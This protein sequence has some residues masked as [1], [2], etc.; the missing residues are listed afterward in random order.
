LSVIGYLRFPAVLLTVYLGSISFGTLYMLNISIQQT[1]AEP[2]YNFSVVLVG[3]AY[4][5]PSLGYFCASLVGGRWT[6]AIMHREAKAAGRY[7]E[8]GK[9]ILRPEDR[10]RENAFLAAAIFP[11]GLL[12][13]GWTSDKGIFWFVP[14]VAN[15]FFG[16]GSMII[17]GTATTMYVSSS[18]LRARKK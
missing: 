7:D 14:L 9:L 15:F 11:A 13:Y 6:D 10:M 1:F 8:A 5:P 2:P 3:L 18:A 4:I 12:W 16:F 17:F